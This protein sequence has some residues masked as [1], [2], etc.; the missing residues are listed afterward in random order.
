MLLKFAFEND[1]E[2]LSYIN[3]TGLNTNYSVEF[4]L[5][6]ND[7][8]EN[9]LSNNNIQ[10]ENSLLNDNIHKEIFVVYQKYTFDIIG[11]ECR[12]DKEIIN[13]FEDELTPT[14][15]AIFISFDKAIDYINKY[16]KENNLKID[17]TSNPEYYDAEFYAEICYRKCHDED[18]YSK[19]LV[20]DKVLF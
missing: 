12:D 10:K 14:I 18:R 13:S 17:I 6:E 20:I 8:V 2:Y 7:L 11:Y 16:I 3:V 15:L 1:G 4:D 19:Y 5:I 9:D